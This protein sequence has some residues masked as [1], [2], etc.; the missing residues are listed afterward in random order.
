MGI[1]YSILETFMDSFQIETPKKIQFQFLISKFGEI[2]PV[3]K[4]AG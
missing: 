1:K 3:K 2:L 4:K